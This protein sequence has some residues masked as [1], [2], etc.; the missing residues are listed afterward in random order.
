MTEL[1]PQSRDLVIRTVFGEAGNEPDDGK[2][3][4]AAVIRNRA[5]SGRYGGTS[6][7]DVVLARGQFEPWARSDA[8][9]RMLSLSPD[10]PAYQRIGSIVDSVFKNGEDITGGATH[11]FAPVAQA[12]LGRNAPSWAKGESTVIGGHHFYAPEGKVTMADPKSWGAVA[13]EDGPTAWGAKPVDETPARFSQPLPGGRNFRQAR[14]GGPQPSLEEIPPDTTT[15]QRGA[16][17]DQN[18]TEAAA[19]RSMQRVATPQNII[20]SEAITDDGGNVYYKDPNTNQLVPTDPKT[21]V[22]LRD[23]RD[24]RLKVFAREEASNLSA[25][26]SAARILAPGLAT[27]APS[28]LPS[29]MATIAERVAPVAREGQLVA[30][31]GQR[32]GVDLPRAVTSDMTGVQQLGKVAT[33]IPLGGTPLRQASQKAIGQLD[34]AVTG[35]QGALG[36]GNVA[37]A[38][39]TAREGITEALRSGPIKERV[40]EL[41]NKVDDLVNPVT[42][43][44]LTNTS[45][46]A[47]AIESRRV[48][49]ALPTSGK[50]AELEEALAR[51]GMNYEGV[52]DLRTYFGEMLDGSKEVPQGLSMGEAKQIYG[53]LTQDLKLIVAKAGGSDGLKAFE[54]ANKAAERWAGI[55]E[56]LQRVLDVRNEEGIFDRI[57]AAAGSSSRADISLLGRVRGAVGPE[58][59]DELASAAISRMGRAPDGAFSPDRFVTAYGKMSERGKQMLFRSTGQS[60]HAD[61]LDDIAT[62]SQRFKSLNQFANPSG[63]GQTLMGGSL[64]GGAWIDPMTA[65]TSIVSARVLST[66]LAKPATARS[67]ASWARSYERATLKPTPASLVGFNQASKLFA[68]AVSREAG[69]PDLIPDL[70]RQLQ[71][72]VP[73]R[74]E[75]KQQ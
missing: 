27:T 22:A 18:M 47:S 70:T 6:P 58:K 54:R 71:G 62:I 41:Y 53:A 55:R 29:A 45:R 68:S 61:A 2:A 64:I 17:E 32:L 65:V 1:D 40:T 67:M 23:P 51:P 74:A 60:S 25:P 44:P 75:D 3:A 31:A 36:S 72:A 19:Q 73:S 7:S 28:R 69:R 13:V 49:A 33:S 10:N 63:T 16:I 56:D 30:E 38:G 50:V 15:L 39:Q 66:I 24:G 4:V 59:W 11:F 37:T 21:Q 42:T 14:E 9:A 48:N 52:K 35:V 8:K 5:V 34:E 12:Q 57:M 26:E 20:S 43:G 46:I